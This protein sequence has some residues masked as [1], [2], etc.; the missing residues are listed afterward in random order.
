[1]IKDCN[2]KEKESNVCRLTNE[3]CDEDICIIFRTYR[4]VNSLT[5]SDTDS[6]DDLSYEKGKSDKTTIIQKIK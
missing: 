6:E 4:L 5:K 2:F 1:M 3:P